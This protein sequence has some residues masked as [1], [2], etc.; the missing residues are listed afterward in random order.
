MRAGEK[1]RVKKKV[2]VKRATRTKWRHCLSEV[3]VVKDD[4]SHRVDVLSS[5][6]TKRILL[7]DLE[8]F[9][10]FDEKKAG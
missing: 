8:V 2:I 7:S 1:I 10:I 5:P 4:F 3:T 9:E 6:H